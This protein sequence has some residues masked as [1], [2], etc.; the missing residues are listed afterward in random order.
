MAEA[1]KDAKKKPIYESQESL[2]QKA[3]RKMQADRLIVQ[4]AYKID[5]YKL[6]AAMFDEVGDYMD[7][8]A[9]AKKCRE[10]AVAG[11]NVLL[12]PSC[13]SFDM[14]TDYE[15]RGR[16]FKDIVNQMESSQA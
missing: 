11:G 5:N 2:Y 14:F 7:A 15:A 9:L 13:A 3:V 10:L 8:P 1:K 16:I 12:S 4:Y 6:A